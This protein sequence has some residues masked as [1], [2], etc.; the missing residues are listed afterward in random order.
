M[1]EEYQ[2]L[3]IIPPV[4]AIALAIRT[5]QVFISLTL[6]IFVGWLIIDQ[7]MPHKAIF[8]T[9]D[10]FVMVFEDAGQTRTVI[11]TLLI[12]SLITLIQVSGGVTGFI[13]RMTRF[14]TKLEQQKNVKGTRL[15]QLFAALGGMLIFVES[16]ISILTV[17]TT[18][19][20]LFKK[21]KLSSEKL[22]Y[23]IDSS[24]APSCRFW[25]LRHLTY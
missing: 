4:L 18:F 19:K 24:S 23:L 21:L 7:F 3:S 10:S 12:G 6:G 15:V 8:S 22:A 20:P 9:I 13:N 11:F 16:N 17:G 2:F 1:L 25:R 14:I 5:K